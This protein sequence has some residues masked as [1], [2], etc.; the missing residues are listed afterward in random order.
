MTSPARFHPPTTTLSCSGSIVLSD[1]SRNCPAVLSQ[2]CLA[3]AIFQ[4]AVLPHADMARVLWSLT[5]LTSSWVCVSGGD[6]SAEIDVQRRIIAGI[7]FAAC[8]DDLVSFV[9]PSKS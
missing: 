3:K 9:S 2:R 5:E 4:I 8:R 6:F 1:G 7:Q